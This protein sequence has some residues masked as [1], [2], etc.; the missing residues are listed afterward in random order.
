MKQI[1]YFLL[2]FASI[3]YSQNVGINNIDPKA[4]LDILGR[5]RIRPVG[6]FVSGTSVTITDNSGY[7]SLN[8]MPAGDFSV[9]LPGGIVS[10]GTHLFIE[11]TTL[12]TATILYN[13]IV[14][15]PK[16]FKYLIYGDIGWLVV[17]S[18]VTN[19]WTT[20]GNTATDPT[21]DFIGTADNQDLS[22]RTNNAEKIRVTKLGNLGI[23]TTNPLARLHVAD[24]SVVFTFNS[25]PSSSTPISPP[26]SGSGTRMMW[27]PAKGAFRVGRVSSSNWDKDS[28][29]TYS[30]ATGID[31]KATGNYTTALGAQTTASGA[32]S[33]S[34]G[35][36]T[37]ASGV[38][39]LALGSSTTASGGN[40]TAIGFFTNASGVSSTSMGNST[41][42]KGNYSTSMGSFT[43]AKG[44]Y[45]TSMG[46]ITNA[47]GDYSTSMGSY[48][49]AIGNSSTAMGKST[50]S[51]AYSSLAIG[52][53]NDTIAGSNITS[54]IANDPLFT[55]GNGY[56]PDALSNALVVYKNGNTD[57]N[58]FTQLGKESEDS[59]A[60]K[61]KKITGIGPDVD[62][63][64]PI[65]HGLTPSKIL[66]VQIF[67]EYGITPTPDKTLPP[68]YTLIPGFEYQFEIDGANI[69]IS[70]KSSNSANIHNKAFKMLITYEE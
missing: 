31:T 18:G 36:K 12:F 32:Y 27:Y 55:V 35:D 11:N 1:V 66:S 37:T 49:I 65:A 20:S 16:S 21:T 47:I 13:G 44:D 67:M 41:N 69:L 10:G 2:F 26:V 63:N 15:P 14:I 28:I 60:I 6:I 38:S 8:G 17:N 3:A 5:L 53:Y 70:N 56:S 52:R 51:R 23:G 30:F 48:T 62:K 7:L 58:G 59:P 57:I 34:M 22:I 43:N 25:L 61:I 24:S 19:A 4:A 46:L 42:A 29:G 50:R 64:K 45:S 68:N 39:S 9:S 33:T 54:W 40:S